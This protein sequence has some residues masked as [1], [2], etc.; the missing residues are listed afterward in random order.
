MVFCSEL[1]PVTT[2][3]KSVTPALI[4]ML[5]YWPTELVIIRP[6]NFFTKNQSEKLNKK[7]FVYQTE[8]YN[9]K[10]IHLPLVKIPLVRKY[11][12]IPWKLIL[13]KVD[14]DPEIFVGHSLLGNYAA[15][16]FAL[17]FKK[18]FSIGLHHS[19][20][21]YILK[22]KGFYNNLLHHANL[23][24]CRSQIIKNQLLHIVGP[25]SNISSKA[26]IANSGIPIHTI[27]SAELFQEKA[28]KILVGKKWSIITVARLQ[29]LKNIDITIKALSKLQNID[30]DYTIIGD[31]EEKDNLQYLVKE[32]KLKEKIKFTGWL[33]KAS[34]S[35]YLTNSDIFIMVSAPETF[36]LVYLEAMAKGCIIIGAKGWGID[37]IVKHEENGFLIE[38]RSEQQIIDLLYGITSFDLKTLNYNSYETVCKFDEIKLSKDYH[39]LLVSVIKKAQRAFFAP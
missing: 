22:E 30:W 32:L 14:F 9:F 1:I 34:I 7:K 16:Q 17:K 21:N 19:D 8:S 15:Y 29:K 4:N 18:P 28:A 20:I 33:D 37:G 26:I 2:D 35:E 38:P 27:L 24:A 31:G 39:N 6:Y 13:K 5:R 23:I 10:V 36:G 12:A 25:N 3:D 11:L